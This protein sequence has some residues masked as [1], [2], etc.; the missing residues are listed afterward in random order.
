MKSLYETKINEAIAL[1][2][3]EPDYWKIASENVEKFAW[4]LRDTE[5]LFLFDA[6][7]EAGFELTEYQ[8]VSVHSDNSV[9][10]SSFY[11]PTN[12]KFK[13]VGPESSL[14]KLIPML[15]RRKYQ[16]IKTEKETLTYLYTGRE[17]SKQ[18]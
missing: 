15:K 8:N 18:H 2:E 4:F 13:I 12:L 6:E 7:D 5:S 16:L 1:S 9:S 3:Q 14:K 17:D 11:K 10:I